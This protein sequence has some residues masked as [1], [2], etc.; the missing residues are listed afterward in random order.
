MWIF[1][2]FFLLLIMQKN[3]RYKKVNFMHIRVTN[4]KQRPLNFTFNTDP[5]QAIGLFFGFYDRFV[6]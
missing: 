1:K 6:G 4:N 5:R 2:H 3:A